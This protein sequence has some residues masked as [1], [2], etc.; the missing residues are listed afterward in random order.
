MSIRPEWT[1][2]LVFCKVCGA[3]LHDG[4]RKQFKVCSTCEKLKKRET[5]V[6]YMEAV[7]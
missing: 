7:Q 6:G 2:S 5:L 1:R 4:K 3:V